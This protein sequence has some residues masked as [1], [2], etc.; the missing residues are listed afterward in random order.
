MDS[1][2]PEEDI[3]IVTTDT[4]RVL[5]VDDQLPFRTIARTVVGVT[6]GFA[7]TAE[8]ESGEEAIEAADRIEPNLVLM[9]I[10]M[11]GINGVEAT[12]RIVADHPGTVVL[13]VSTYQADDLPDGADSCGAAAYV[14]KED[15]SPTLLGSLWEQHR[16]TP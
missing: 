11:P 5:I 4:V 6:K 15:F 12:R 10:N 3:P 1:D 8:A 9:D 2:P 16:P 7:V 14:H 13:L